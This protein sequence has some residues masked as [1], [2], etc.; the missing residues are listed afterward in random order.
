MILRSLLTPDDR[1]RIVWATMS[2]LPGGSDRGVVSFAPTRNRSL[3]RDGT[4]RTGALRQKARAVVKSCD[5]AAAWIVAHGAPVRV[6]PDLIAAG[7]PVHITVHDDPAWGNVLLTRR[8]LPLA[9]LLAFDLNRSLRGARSVDVVSEPMARRYGARHGVAPTIVHRGL[10]GPVA[11]SPRYDRQQGLSVAVLGS[12]Y[13]FREVRVLMQALRLASE[14]LKVRARLTV[15]GGVDEAHVRSLCPPGLALEVTGHVAEPEGVAK[16]R[17]CFMLYLSYPFGLRGKVLRTT[18]FPT[19]LSTYVMAARPVLLHMPADS[20]VAFLAD[21]SPPYA[22][23]WDS[24][25]P[26][27]G[28]NAIARIWNDDRAH[29]SCHLAAEELRKR[30]FDL[31]RNRATLLHALN[32]LADG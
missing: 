26:E 19:K 29:Q 25:N 14:R 17:E 4:V 10:V 13:G 22:T 16:L 1:E 31:S 9:P 6:A 23:L 3:L 18:S 7:I 24:L 15:I 8:Y 2:P 11:P 28:A 27:D 30:H 5:A 32:A 20:S 12:T 21:T